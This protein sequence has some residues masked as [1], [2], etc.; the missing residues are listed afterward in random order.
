[1]KTIVEKEVP[2]GKKYGDSDDESEEGNV[3]LSKSTDKKMDKE[4]GVVDLFSLES[5]KE[6]LEP[7][8][9]NNYVESDDNKEN[10][11]CNGEDIVH[12]DF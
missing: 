6:N 3:S 7:P 9:T 2:T 5:N 12:Y 10:V 1:M 8:F 11:S 4:V